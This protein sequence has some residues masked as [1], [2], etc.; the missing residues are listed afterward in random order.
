MQIAQI[1]GNN[2]KKRRQKLQMTQS[3]LA[4]RSGLHRSY[5]AG[6]E[7]GKRNVSLKTIQKLAQALEMQVIDLLR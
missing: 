4:V 2:I 7:S 6:I 5:L 1:L 3:D